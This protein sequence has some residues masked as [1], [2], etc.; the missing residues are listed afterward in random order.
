MPE[1]ESKIQQESDPSKPVERERNVSFFVVVVVAENEDG[2]AHYCSVPP[3]YSKR[4]KNNTHKGMLVT[5]AN[6]MR[7]YL[8]SFCQDCRFF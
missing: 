3:I 8:Q 4:K 1:K 5:L 2:R 7:F 6:A